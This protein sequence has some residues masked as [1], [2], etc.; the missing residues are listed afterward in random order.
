MPRDNDLIHKSTATRT[1]WDEIKH[2]SESEE[3]RRALRSGAA[4]A[5]MRAAAGEAAREAEAC[6]LLVELAAGETKVWKEVRR[7]IQ[8]QTTKHWM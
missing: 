7:E 3:R 2:G 1:H 6:A 5:A 8:N 4:E